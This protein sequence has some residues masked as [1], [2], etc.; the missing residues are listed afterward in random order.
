MHSGNFSCF[1]SSFCFTKPQFS[2]A[3]FQLSE[4]TSLAINCFAYLRITQPP[5]IL[6]SLVKSP[7]ITAFSIICFTHPL[8]KDSNL[9]SD[10]LCSGK[11]PCEDPSHNH[12]WVHNGLLLLNTC[13]RFCDYCGKHRKNLCFLK[14][15]VEQYH[16]GRTHHDLTVAYRFPRQNQE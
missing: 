4:D 12:T 5:Q 15:H 16:I 14:R 7:E 10:I 2:T 9:L 3:T 13:E 8:T 1:L 6:F 11:M